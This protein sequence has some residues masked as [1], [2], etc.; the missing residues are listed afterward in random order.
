MIGFCLS[1]P[2]MRLYGLSY[3]HCNQ[4]CY[5]VILTYFTYIY[6]STFNTF[7]LEKLLYKF[8]WVAWVPPHHWSLSSQHPKQIQI[9]PQ[10]YCLSLVKP[11]RRLHSDICITNQ[12][13]KVLWLLMYLNNS[14]SYL[15]YAF[16]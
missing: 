6:F 3:S 5:I 14:Y 4:Y 8:V 10:I 12:G 13:T 15:F 7:H 1:L 2:C 9:P 16:I 11:Q